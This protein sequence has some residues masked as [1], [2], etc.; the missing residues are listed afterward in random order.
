MRAPAVILV[1]LATTVLVAAPPQQIPKLT[2]A[3]QDSRVRLAAVSNCPVEFSAR[4]QSLAEVVVVNRSAQHRSGQGVHLS[5]QHPPNSISAAEV[6]VHA[7]SNKLRYLPLEGIG[8]Q[9]D[10]SRSF[11]LSPS[12]G[13]DSLR[14][15][16]LW[17]DEA[18]SILSVDLI[19][20]TY[21]DGTAWRHTSGSTCHASINGVMLINSQ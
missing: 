17:L 4:R 16:D 9:P 3:P 10:L 19:S 18:G 15:S 12:S 21:A 8:A 7:D 2:A 13:S 6:V 5:L 20:V 11:H 14:S 1:T